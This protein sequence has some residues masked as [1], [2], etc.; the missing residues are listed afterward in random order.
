MDLVAEG[1]DK[2]LYTLYVTQI[3]N[4]YGIGQLKWNYRSFWPTYLIVL[5]W[6]IEMN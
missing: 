3:V 2:V 6:G 4:N 1:F 5:S